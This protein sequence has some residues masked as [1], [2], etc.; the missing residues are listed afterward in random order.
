MICSGDL[1]KTARRSILFLLAAVLASS[2]H[3]TTPKE[4]LGFNAG[5]DYR[6]ANYTQLEAYF[7]KVASQSDRIKVEQI[8]LTAE[9]RPQYMAVITSAENQKK[10]E[11]YKDI[12]RRLAQ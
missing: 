6:L 9:G 2:Q 10:L 5:D 3:I 4:E 8:G 7:K 1:M 12:A 11:R